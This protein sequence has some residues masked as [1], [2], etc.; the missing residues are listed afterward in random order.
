MSSIPA[1]FRNPVYHFRGPSTFPSPYSITA[2]ALQ[3]YG[4]SAELF[5]TTTIIISPTIQFNVKDYQYVLKRDGDGNATEVGM[6]FL[7]VSDDASVPDATGNMVAAGQVVDDWIRTKTG[8]A[9]TDPI[10]ALISYMHPEISSGTIAQLSATEKA[11]LGFTHMGAY[12]GNGITSNSPEAYH[13]HRFGCA[14]GGVIG[15]TYGYPCN[16]HTVSLQGVNQAVLNQNCQLVDLIVGHG[17]EFPGNYEDSIFRPV[18]INAALMFYRD[19]LMQEAYLLNDTS[20]YFYCAANKLTVLN[21]ACNL[22]HNQAA[23]QEVYGAAEGTALWNQFLLRYTNATGFS[24]TYYPN[25][26]TDFIPLWKQQGLTAADITPFTI[27]QYNSYDAHR[28][29]GTPFSGPMPVMP[30]AG[31]VCAAQ[32]TADIVAE[33]IQIYA[34]PYDAGP[35]STVAVLWGFMVPITERTG[36]TAIEYL[37]YTADIFQLLVYDDARVNAAVT[38]NPDWAKSVWFLSTFQMLEVIFGG[39]N[40]PAPYTAEQAAAAVQA[41]INEQPT[42]S[43]FV[44]K[45]MADFPTQPGLL[46]SFSMLKVVLNWT[47]IM[48]EGPIPPEDAYIEFM[49]AVQADFLSAEN[50]VVTNPSGI[51]YNILPAAFNLVSNGL[52]GKNDLVTIETICTA[53]D[54][55]E[56]QLNK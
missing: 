11:E 25:Q 50:L 8:L 16:V 23:F 14:W 13:N 33:F 22:P 32:S 46:A 42:S 47:A 12:L 39:T 56:L 26:A 34:D 40:P 48:Q 9:P 55:K 20:W 15:T 43:Q 19:W 44:A 27:D 17:I 18:Y 36:I 38:P 35:L 6:Y 41:L 3:D 28:R 45:N 53:V 24:F 2:A 29:L 49:K 30:P 7:P 5:G 54:I 4:V 21:I 10:Y 51:Q 37:Y 52:Y 31:V 1:T